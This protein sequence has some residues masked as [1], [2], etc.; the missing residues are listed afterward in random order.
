MG[1]SPLLLFLEVYVISKALFPF[2]MNITMSFYLVSDDFIF[3][4]DNTFLKVH[5][6]YLI[7]NIEFYCRTQ[8]SM[9]REQ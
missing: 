6:N 3:N 7:L 4:V 8:C 5:L 1:I 2:L 9:N